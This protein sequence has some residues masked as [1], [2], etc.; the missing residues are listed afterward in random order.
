MTGVN[1]RSQH[2]RVSQTDL[3]QMDNFFSSGMSTATRRDANNP[4]LNN[5]YPLPEPLSHAN[6]LSSSSGYKPRERQLEEPQ[7]LHQLINRLDALLMVLKTCRGR[8]CTHPWETLFPHGDVKILSDALDHRY[9]AFFAAKIRW[10][11][12]DARMAISPRARGRCGRVNRLIMR[13]VRK[14]LTNDGTAASGYRRRLKSCDDF[15]DSTPIC[16]RQAC[17]QTVDCTMQCRAVLVSWSHELAS[18]GPRTKPIAR[19]IC[20]VV[21]EPPGRCKVA[22]QPTS[23]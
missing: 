14:W 23:V 10:S 2:W 17:H 7:R 16:I 3:W 21:V 1:T 15:Q 18:L 9:D 12:R 13:W 19:R 5:S 11:S 20:Q 8:Q 6:I 22:V 4:A